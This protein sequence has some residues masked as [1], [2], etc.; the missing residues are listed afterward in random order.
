MAT[1]GIEWVNK[2]HGRADN[3]KNCDNCARGFYNKLSGTKQFEY[4]DDLA[5]DQDFEQAGMGYPSTGSDNSYADNVDIM[6]FAGHSSKNGLFFGISNKDN[7][8][9]QPSEM[10]LG[11]RQLKWL[12]TDSCQFLDASNVT[13]RLR[14]VFD[15]LHYILGFHTICHDVQDRGDKFASKLNAGQT[16][17]NAWI[18]ACAET[19][20]SSTQCA[21]LRAD[22]SR[23]DTYNDHWIGK[24]FVSSN[25]KGNITLT[26]LKT[27]C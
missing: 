24:G 12:I 7:G 17:R 2:Y 18:Q 6:F 5:W 1:K 23:S 16:I 9:A 13:T 14:N 3:L 27:T 22:D 20:S 10:K 8:T 4:G 11:D 21:Y 25:P 26:H 15:G 19:E